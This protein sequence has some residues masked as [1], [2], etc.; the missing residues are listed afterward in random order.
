MIL[1]KSLFDE[2]P[3]VFMNIFIC[4]VY[5]VGTYH[6]NYFQPVKLELQN[7]H[8][9]FGFNIRKNRNQRGNKSSYC[10]IY[11]KAQLVKSVEAIV[12]LEEDSLKCRVPITILSFIFY[13]TLF[14]KKLLVLYI[15]FAYTFKRLFRLFWF[16]II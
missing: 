14:K 10:N 9:I 4:L 3:V 15:S 2:S 12:N 6:V 16:F 11:F 1:F 13:E 7:C 8:V 5:R